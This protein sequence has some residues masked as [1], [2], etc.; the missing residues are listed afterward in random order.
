M[1]KASPQHLHLPAMAD[2]DIFCIAAPRTSCVGDLGFRPRHLYL[3]DR[4]AAPALTLGNLSMDVA[5]DLTQV[6]VSPLA[7]LV[8]VYDHGCVTVQAPVLPTYDRCTCRTFT[9]S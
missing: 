1:V 2:R 9:T 3:S 8:I 7:F 6:L 5:D 4:T